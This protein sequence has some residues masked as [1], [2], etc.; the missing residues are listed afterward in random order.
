MK[1]I[2]VFA[3][4]MLG[5]WFSLAAP[6]QAVVPVTN[7]GYLVVSQAQA[8]GPQTMVCPVGKYWLGIDG[9]GNNPTCSD[10]DGTAKPGTAVPAIT[11]QAAL[12]G[13]FGKGATV[14]VG[15]APL[16][17]KGEVRTVIFYRIT[18]QQ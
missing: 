17:F 9:H 6:V 13:A 11:P 10:G 5:S 4:L 15:V 18:R 14:A 12:D 16:F 2:V 1:K 7:D 8:A 3:A